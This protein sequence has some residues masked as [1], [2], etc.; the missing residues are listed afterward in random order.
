MLLE[1]AEAEEIKRSETE[2]RERSPKEGF[3]REVNADR[4]V[5]RLAGYRGRGDAENTFRA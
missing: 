1:A 3:R 4:A 2:R 5:L